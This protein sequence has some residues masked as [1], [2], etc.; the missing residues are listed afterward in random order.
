MFDIKKVKETAEKEY[1]EEKEKEAKEKIKVKLK[2]LDKA[3]QVV[4]NLERELDDLYLQIS[5]SV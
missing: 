2:E 1:R 3:K 5:E 4:R